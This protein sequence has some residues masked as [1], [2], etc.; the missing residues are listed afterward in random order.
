MTQSGQGEEPSARPAHEG[1]VLPSDGGEPLLPGMTGTPAPAG[2]AGG[3][4]WGGSWG[5]EQQAPQQGQ[6][7][8][9]AAPQWGAPG[10]PGEQSPPAASPGPLP[11]EGAPAPSYGGQAPGYGGEAP[12]YGGQ[13]MAPGGYGAAQQPAYG[14]PDPYQQHQ[15]QYPAQ[16]AAPLPPAVPDAY[17]ATG[18]PL[19]P[20]ADGATQ[21]IPPVPAGPAAPVDEGATQYIPPV[22]AAPAASVHEAATQYMPPVTPGALPPES[23]GEE[24]RYLGQ[25]PRQAAPAHSDAEA[26]Q[27]IPPYSAQAQGQGADRQPPA[28]FDNLFRG[29]PAGDGGPAGS[30]QQLPRV[31]QPDAHPGPAQS[32][33]HPAQPSY[34]DREYDD[35][36]RRGGRSRVPLIAAIGVG[37]VVLGVGAGALLSS[38]GGKDQGG[39]DKTVAAASPAGQDSASP[40]ADPA[41]A[42]AVELDKLL[43]DSGSSRAS[44][45]QAVADVKRCDNL[46]QAAANLRDAAGQRGEL[47]TRLGKLSVDKLP[48][49]ADLTAALTKAWQASAAADNHYAAWAGQAKNRKVCHKGHA[50]T[51]GETQAGNRESGTA[52]AQKT[53]AAALWNAIAT[54]YGLTQRQPTQL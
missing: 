46:D 3:R 48:G 50:R 49:N 51:T 35:G 40:S 25:V 29:G 12:S 4:A 26:T 9:A 1:I 23:G 54:K 53:K 14:A 2:P 28:E 33:Y 7:Y 36:G 41:R 45:I 21:Y 15:Q 19:P 43:A 32:S 31:Q 8:P 13:P 22:A 30:T 47:V 44:V 18:A 17:P 34:D 11:P 6:G 16:P 27:Y 39:D 37:I 10:G 5:P 52:S 20:T 42:Q 38:G 24:T